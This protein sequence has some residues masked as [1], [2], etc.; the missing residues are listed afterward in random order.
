M[1][2]YTVWFELRINYAQ[3]AVVVHSQGVINALPIPIKKNVYNDEIVMF[4]FLSSSV[5]NVSSDISAR[6]SSNPYETSE[7]KFL[8]EVEKKRT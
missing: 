6:S 4:F 3:K 7:D 8:T 5:G 1:V 2:R